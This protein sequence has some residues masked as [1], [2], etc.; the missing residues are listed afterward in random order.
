MDSHRECSEAQLIHL[1]QVGS[2]GE[3][4]RAFHALYEANDLKLRIHLMYKGLQEFEIDDVCATVWERALDGIES[5]V[6]KGIPYL[7]W[8]K[9]TARYVTLEMY[10]HK[11]KHQRYTQ[12]MKDDFDAED[13]DVWTHPLLSLLEGEDD[14]A[15]ERWRQ[16]VKDVLD[17]LIKQL[18]SD[19][20]DVLE[21]LHEMD[22][23][24]EETAELLDWKRRKVYDTYYRARKRLEAMLIEHGITDSS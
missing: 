21:A 10:R 23:S 16:E 4:E 11:Q 3:A 5:Y 17:Q 14:E 2:P 20:K 1:I 12:Q 6:Y 13:H 19:Y 9:S 24:A 18:P 15:A 8:L 22:L 7:A